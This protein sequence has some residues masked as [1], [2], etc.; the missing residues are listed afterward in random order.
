MLVAMSFSVAFFMQ[1]YL[2]VQQKQ[3]IML[4]A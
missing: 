3:L 2:P 4:F 1:E